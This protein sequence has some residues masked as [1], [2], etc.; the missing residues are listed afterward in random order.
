MISSDYEMKFEY[1]VTAEINNSSLSDYKS[2]IN[3][4]FT[5]KKSIFTEIVIL[6]ISKVP[7]EINNTKLDD[8]GDLFSTY[9]QIF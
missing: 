3:E 5:M 9:W 6:G 2:L 8:F 7:A 1:F 4:F